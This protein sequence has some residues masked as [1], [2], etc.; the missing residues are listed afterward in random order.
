MVK[1]FTQRGILIAILTSIIVVSTLTAIESIFALWMLAIFVIGAGMVYIAIRRD[2]TQNLEMAAAGA[3]T[4][5][6]GGANLIGDIQVVELTT[7]KELGLI[8]A[9]G[10]LVILIFSTLAGWK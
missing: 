9:V 3:A 7:A 1:N 6:L 8:V 2:F 5:V 4:M 10:M